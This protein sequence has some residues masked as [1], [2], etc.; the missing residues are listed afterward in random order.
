MSAT[1]LKLGFCGALLGFSLANIGFTSWDEV[2]AM[3]TFADLRLFLTFV[4]GV[5]LLTAAFA[6][7][8]WRGRPDWPARPIHRGTLLGGVLFGLGWVISGACPG[9]I[10]AQIGEGK[11]YA[12]FSL[13]GVLAGNWLYGTYLERRM[14]TA[15]RAAASRLAS[16]R[17]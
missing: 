8:R 3:F 14:G 11:L 4:T 5:S 6:V 15:P 12:L 10:L 16:S 9:V 7:I 17:T 1:L 2:Y 13:V